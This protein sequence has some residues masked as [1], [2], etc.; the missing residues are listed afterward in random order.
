MISRSTGYDA[1]VPADDTDLDITGSTR[2]FSGT[3]THT[4]ETDP[5]RET[6]RSV[7]P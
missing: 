1:I 4:S 5:K 7:C 6:P 2:P 3:F